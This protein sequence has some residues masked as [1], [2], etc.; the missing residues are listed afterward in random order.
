MHEEQ[1]VQIAKILEEWN[2]L[3]EAA[4]STEQLDGY[5]YEAIDI[6]VTIEIVNGSN[7]VRKSIEQVLTQ[8]FNIKL[9]QAKL[10]EASEK[11]KTILV[12]K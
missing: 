3:G 10:N 4:N 5:R 6:I 8:A 12:A 9:N 1:I 11:V 2:P 7:K